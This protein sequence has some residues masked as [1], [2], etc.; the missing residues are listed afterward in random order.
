[1]A[2]SFLTPLRCQASLSMNNW[3]ETREFLKWAAG[4]PYRR[5]HRLYHRLKT[6]GDVAGLFGLALLALIVRGVRKVRLYPIEWIVKRRLPR[7]RIK[8]LLFIPSLGLGGAQ[9]QLVSF[10]TQYNRNKFD[11]VLVTMDRPDKF[12]EPHVRSLEIPV[13]YLN[14]GT[15]SHVYKIS[16]IWRLVRYLLAHP[17]HIL[18]AWM[19]YALMLGV[20]AGTLAGTPALIG[21]IRSGKPTRSPWHFPKW[22]RA[23]DMLTGPLHTCFIANSEAVRED[24]HQWS[25][26]A[27]KKILLVYNGIDAV[28][29]QRQ[30]KQNSHALIPEL[31]SRSSHPLVGIIGRLWKEKDH[32]TFLHAAK[33]INQTEPEVHFVI[34]GD[35]P[36]RDSIEAMCDRL[37]LSDHVVLLPAQQDVLSVLRALT[38]FVLTST[39]EGFPN[40]LLEAAVADVPIVT[41]AAGGAAEVIDNDVTGFVVPCGDADAIAQKVC[42]LLRNS[43][44]RNQMA[45]ASKER[46]ANLFSARTNIQQME[47]IYEKS[48][49]TPHDLIE[50]EPGASIGSVL[51]GKENSA[52][53]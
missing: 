32:E 26:V 42:R 44:L 31:S 2:R 49:Y 48:L 11:I 6:R 37:E 43:A 45:T 40:V 28:A 22:Q 24:H 41:T 35:G 53:P 10:L 39:Y 3:N 19:H 12:F 14:D 4:G 13:V 5:C 18:H 16:M 30:W 8:V 36:T 52:S 9:R 25:F 47:T 34:V 38:V 27:R 15:Y 21:A 7:D 33:I 51:Q 29:L 17:C 46:V 50:P 23:I 1:M 20:I